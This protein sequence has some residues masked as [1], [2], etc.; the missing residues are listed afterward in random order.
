MLIPLARLGLVLAFVGVALLFTSLRAAHALPPAG[1][2]EVQVTAQASVA[3]RLGQETIDFIG[4][5]TFVRGA[6]YND[7]GFDVVDVEMTALSLTGES[8]TGPVTITQNTTTQSLGEIRGA[9]PG[10]DWPATAYIDVFVDVG[11]PAS[12]EGTISKHNNDPIRVE[13]FYQGTPLTIT[14]WPPN[15]VPWEADL[16]PCVSLAPVLPK[17]VCVTALTMTI[18]GESAGVGGFTELPVLAAPPEGGA[19]PATWLVAGAGGA[20]AFVAL[21]FL[22][23]RRLAS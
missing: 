19:P 7:G 20:I 2:D 1:T 4:T 12:P 3:S 11:A 17:D 5:A 18:S 21:A 8:L 22:L 10:Q 23:R 16:T 13:P 15:A 14:S 6:P 9:S